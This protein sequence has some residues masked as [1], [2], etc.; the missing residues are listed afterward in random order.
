MSLPKEYTPKKLRDIAALLQYADGDGVDVGSRALNFVAELFEIAADPRY[1]SELIGIR[2]R[3][4]L[5][6]L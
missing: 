6:H 1:S 4:Q 5:N 3:N 2:V